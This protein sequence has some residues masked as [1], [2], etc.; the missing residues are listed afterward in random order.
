MA[1]RPVADP[2]AGM[3][4]GGGALRHPCSGS[5]PY[6]GR[7]RTPASTTASQRSPSLSSAEDAA[8]ADRAAEGR[9]LRRL[10]EAVVT[11]RSAPPAVQ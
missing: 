2:W 9:G 6:A 3:G 4:E 5:P 1:G 7:S 10:G 8:A 11:R